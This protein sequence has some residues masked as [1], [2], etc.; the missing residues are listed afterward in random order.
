MQNF[1]PARITLLWALAVLASG[2]VG[3]A[4]LAA[5]QF[6]WADYYTWTGLSTATIVGYYISRYLDEH[7][8]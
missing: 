3:L 5:G 8:N 4:L 1:Q 6:K 2:S 7:S